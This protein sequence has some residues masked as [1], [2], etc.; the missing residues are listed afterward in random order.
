KV[1]KDESD[2]EAMIGALQVV[3]GFSSDLTG[4]STLH[5]FKAVVAVV[6][7]EKLGEFRNSLPDAIFLSHLVSKEQT[8]VMVVV[9]KADEPKLDKTMKLLELKPLAIP[10]DLPQ[11]PAEAFRRASEERASAAANREKVEADMAATRQKY[12]TPLLAVR[13]LTEVARKMLD[14]ARVSGSMKR[15]AMISGFIPSK[16]EEEMKATF[17]RWIVHSEPAAHEED[18]HAPTLMDN[19]KALGLFELITREQGIPG[20]G[21]VDPTPLVSFVFPIFFGMMF[22]DVGH[23]IIL[24]LFML[25]VRQRGMGN[26]KRWA[27]IFIVAGV[28][29]IIF[30]AVFGE[31][32][33]LSLYNFIPIPPVVEVIQRA[34]GAHDTFNITG[35]Y[36]VM[37]VAILI[38]VAHLVTGLG[39]DIYQAL[40][41]HKG[42]ELALEKIPALTMYLS[43]VG[44]GLAFIGVGFGFDVLKS[45][46]PAPLVG[47]PNNELGAI[48]LAVLLPSMLWLLAGRTIF[49]AL[50]KVKGVSAVGALANGGLEVFERISQ[51]LSNTISYV[52]LAVLLLV[53]AGLLLI[54]NLY[55]GPSGI[56]APWPDLIPIWIILNL[57]ILAFE[58]FIV[59]V[60]DLRL[61]LYEFFT[62]FFLGTGTPFRKIL[63]DR[64]R[65]RINWL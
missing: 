47:I 49:I 32:F 20:H 12:A 1:Q 29:S 8:L 38:G 9:R 7:N 42:V 26:M 6:G 5:L 36:V 62:K 41:E 50:G 15:M 34:A 40:K 19:S 3:S 43:G 37:E 18:G 65:I 55:F 59:Y 58:V 31:F 56:L 44:Y 30:G 28:S 60:Q 21:E 22:A 33:E 16:K 25:L 48:S 46:A 10:P 17:G 54:T 45:S 24:T 63:P 64:V 35:V 11:N 57:M 23:G 53:H 52:R 39:L 51:F 4:L 14:E 13:E 61:H 27:N 2:A